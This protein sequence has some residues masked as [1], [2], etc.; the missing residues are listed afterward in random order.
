MSAAT[1]TSFAAIVAGVS[2]IVA[3]IMQ[4]YRIIRDKK[5][6][7]TSIESALDH[8]PAIRQQ[9]EL[10][11]FGEAIKHLNEI[12]VTQAKHIDRQDETI[13]EQGSL[14]DSQKKE[15]DYLKSQLHLV[16]GQLSRSQDMIA[17]LSER[18]GNL[19]GGKS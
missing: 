14:I 19:R 16:E 15:N 6:E 13:M 18:I 10:G 11:N 3:L 1:A 8:Q 2:G 7:R 17:E 5:T 4:F 12:I 9:L